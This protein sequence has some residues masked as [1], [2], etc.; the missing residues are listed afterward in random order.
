MNLEAIALRRAEE[1]VSRRGAEVIRNPSWT[2]PKKSAAKR[3]G[4]RLLCECG[5]CSLCLKREWQRRWREK[6]AKSPRI[7]A[8]EGCLKHVHKGD[9]CQRHAWQLATFGVV[10]PNKR[11]VA[12]AQVIEKARERLAARGIAA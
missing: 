4:H 2:P 8:A 7:C 9:H 1:Q 11:R 6:R 3:S 5:R 10:F 12:S